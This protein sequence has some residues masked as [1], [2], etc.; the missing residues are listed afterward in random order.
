MYD[1][2]E[3]LEDDPEP[4]IE[5][6]SQIACKRAICSSNI[7]FI[8]SLN[9]TNIYTRDNDKDKEHT[10]TIFTSFYI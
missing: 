1:S 7:C 8:Q 3:H 10:E 6:G 9:D 5:F 4:K 2:F